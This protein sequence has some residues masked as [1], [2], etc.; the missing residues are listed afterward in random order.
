M[1]QTETTDPF[2]AAPLNENMD[3]VEAALGAQDA[4]VLELE[5]CRILL[6]TYQSVPGAKVPRAFDLGERPA[7]LLICHHVVIGDRYCIMIGD[8][9]VSTGTVKGVWLTDT[10]F[11]V[12][13]R[14]NE[15]G[16]YSFIAFFG[17]WKQKHF[18]KP[19]A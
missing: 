3:K 12:N 10:G 4:R 2:S 5:H 7:A 1:Q 18:P 16:I 9:H 17:D 6:G 13:D 14:Y 15:N 11:V 19:E 8:D